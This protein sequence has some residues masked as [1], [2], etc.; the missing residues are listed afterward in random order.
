MNLFR[1][2]KEFITRRK[3]PQNLL[4]KGRK[5]LP[6]SSF[7]DQEKLYRSYDKDDLDENDKIKLET[8]KFPD[9]S[10]NWSK[11]SIPQD[12]LFIKNAKQNDGCYSFTVLT[13]RYNKMA[14]PI[15]DPTDDDKYPNYSHVEVRELN[16]DE[17]IYFEPPKGR[18][19]KSK[20]TKNR[21]MVYRYNLQRKLLIEFETN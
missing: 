11:L 1:R 15:H 7:Q 21:R 6:T 13:S 3:Y 12:I 2:F 20:T 14:T 19:S 18:K 10:C 5:K 8:I 9:F 16:P 17:N 4:I